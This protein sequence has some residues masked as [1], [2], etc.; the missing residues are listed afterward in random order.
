VINTKT[1]D[2]AKLDLA[3]KAYIQVVSVEPQARDDD[4]SEHVRVDVARRTATGRVINCATFAVESPFWRDA[5]AAKEDVSKTW[6]R[7]VLLHT[8]HTFPYLARRQRVQR[9]E[10]V[11]LPPIEAARELLDTQR[12]ELA[13]EL[14]SAAPRPNVVQMALQGSLLLQVNAGPLA[15]GDAFLLGVAG[16]VPSAEQAALR[17]SVR[18]FLQTL[19]LGVETNRRLIGPDQQQFQIKLEE[20]LVR[21]IARVNKWGINVLEQQQPQPQQL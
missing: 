12:R 19:Q 18:L 21:F 6:K 7:R 20:G 10:V 4:G 3:S 5:D 2:T 1:V 17:A 14:R 16:G 9:E 13:R 15:I 11:E 8:A